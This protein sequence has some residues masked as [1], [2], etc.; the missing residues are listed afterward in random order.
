[1]ALLRNEVAMERDIQGELEQTE[2]ELKDKKM[3]A[4]TYLME[5][6]NGNV[7]LRESIRKELEGIF[8][9]EHELEEDSLKEQNM[10]LRIENK[11]KTIQNNQQKIDVAQNFLQ[12][13]AEDKLLYL[14][15]T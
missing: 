1:M 4:D 5:V 9:L 11:E 15:E 7:K 3:K 8:K 10:Q 6:S 13:Y 14:G 2:D 12:K